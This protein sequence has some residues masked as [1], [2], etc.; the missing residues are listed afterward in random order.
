MR[1]Q[2]GMAVPPDAAA[3]VF[4]ALFMTLLDRP[5]KSVDA[6]LGARYASHQLELND[7]GAE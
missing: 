6:N 1:R 5:Y 3:I 2:I 7:A 4:R